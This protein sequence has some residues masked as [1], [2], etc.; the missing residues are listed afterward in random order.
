MSRNIETQVFPFN[1]LDSRGNRSHHLRSGEDL[2]VGQM[3]E[4]KVHVH[5]KSA[6][7]ARYEAV[8]GKREQFAGQNLSVCRL[9]NLDERRQIGWLVWVKTES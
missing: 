8:S 9:G 4:G 5:A 6:T 2:A 1:V 7:G 3:F